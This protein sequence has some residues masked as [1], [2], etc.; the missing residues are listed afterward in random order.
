MGIHDWVHHASRGCTSCTSS[1]NSTYLMCCWATQFRN[2]PVCSLHTIT[3]C[4]GSATKKDWKTTADS[5]DCRDNDWCQPASSIQ[6]L[7]ISRARKWAWNITAVQSYPWCYL[8]QLLVPGKWVRTLYASTIRLKNR[9]LHGDHHS[10]VH[11]DQSYSLSNPQY[12]QMVL[13]L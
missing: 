3:V 11:S 6:Q 7:Y 8:P 10:D 13:P 5:Q 4:F 12:H 9:N 1:G 2:N